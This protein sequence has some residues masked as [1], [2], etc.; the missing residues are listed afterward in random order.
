MNAAN[1]RRFLSTLVGALLCVG[2]LSADAQPTPVDA[3]DF[4]VPFDAGVACNFPL[5]IEGS[6][7]RLYSREFTDKHGLLNTEVMGMG[8]AFRFTNIANGKSASQKSQDAHQHTIQYPDGS[9]KITTD[10]AV[11]IVMFPTDIPAGPS[12]VYYNG[13][14][15]LNLTAEGVGTLELPHAHARD[16]CAELS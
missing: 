14:T 15:V 5:T 4:T 9:Q 11:L 7:A 3:P 1:K 12:T 2:S 16:I 6:G 10:G 13:H 8:F